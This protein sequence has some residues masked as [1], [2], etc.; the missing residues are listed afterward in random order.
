MPK[1]ETAA[2]AGSGHELAGV[3]L[4]PLVNRRYLRELARFR[5]LLFSGEHVTDDRAEL[6]VRWWRTLDEVMATHHRSVADILWELL[7]AKNEGAEAMV[8]AMN[9][10]YELLAASRG[11]AGRTLTA[12]LLGGGSSS[13]TQLAFVRFHEEMSAIASWEEREVLPRAGQ[14][15]TKAD[16]CRV[17]TH[18]IA[19]QAAHG[20]MEH[21]MP[22]LCEGIAGD[23]VE[24]VLDAMPLALRSAYLRAWLPAHERLIA[25]LWPRRPQPGPPENTK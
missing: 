22:W 11:E 10:R 20:R 24:R 21:V 7:R 25:Q 17:E 2:A 12:L 4:T 8:A 16:W 14:L 23:G 13:R 18:V 6:L 15:F 9:T 19:T 3:V 1:D 5:M